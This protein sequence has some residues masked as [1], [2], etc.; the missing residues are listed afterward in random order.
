MQP[1]EKTRAPLRS[2]ESGQVH[3]PAH[4]RLTVVFHPDLTRIGASMKLG[5]IDA[6]GIMRLTASVIG[7]N[8]PLFSDDLA[9]DE[10]H[11]SRRALT[12]SHHARGLLL[13]DASGASHCQLGPD[14][15]ASMAV[16]FD[17]LKRGLSIRFGH[18]VVCWLRL[19]QFQPDFAVHVT[20]AGDD[21]AG[22][23][24]EA[25][26][27]RRL[28]DI[29]ARCDLPTLLCG[30]TGVGKEIVARAIHVR[31]HR[32]KAPLVS[33]N[34]AAVPEALADAELFGAAKGAYTGAETRDGYF[35]LADGGTLFLDEIGEAPLPLQPKLL[36]TLQEGEVPVVGGKT[37]Q[38]DV[39]I[40]AAS[41]ANLSDAS[42][43]KQPLLHRLAGI[44]I[45]IPP[46]SARREDLGVLLLASSARVP[47]SRDVSHVKGASLAKGISLD[48][49]HR[50]VSL[51]LDL[52]KNKPSIAAAWAQFMHDALNTEWPGNVRAFLLA[53]Q[54]YALNLSDHES[55]FV[56]HSSDVEDN[57][58][59][60][61][62]RGAQG[63]DRGSA[64]RGASIDDARLKHEHEAANY[65]IAETA[66][67][68]G[69]SRQAVY[70]RL[71]Q[72]PDLRLA[73]Q[74]P[75]REFLVAIKRVGDD[76]DALSRHLKISR[77][78]IVQR[79][80]QLGARK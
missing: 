41:D 79:L 70:R 61:D 30:E 53:A 59:D 73:G 68:L 38:V 3:A 62:K 78:A 13:A 45:D 14:K 36:R 43:F 10:S 75:D 76:I 77:V 71:Q 2:R 18:G 23:S 25:S 55:Q 37:K 42:Q 72:I 58:S 67:R 1:G 21:F 74:L 49:S 52:A 11:V 9:L 39:R 54:R 48:S 31:S 24:P 56:C 69:M 63:R 17:E 32:N 40:I 60:S 29:A 28:I 65:E 4:L 66:R 5:T 80:K 20:D 57:D 33:V 64:K 6:S 27:V 46:L 26:A 8:A 44:T 51:G 7:R 12:L 34:M 16:T 15:S 19:S 50:S 22:V 47:G 35:Q